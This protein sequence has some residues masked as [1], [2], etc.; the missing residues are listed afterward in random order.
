MES[1]RAPHQYASLD[2]ALTAW[3]MP[4]E[5]WDLIERFTNR[6][7][8]AAYIETLDSIRAVRF[9][10][11]PDLFIHVALTTGFVSEEEARESTGSDAVWFWGEQQVWGVDHPVKKVSTK[12]PPAKPATPAK[13]PRT[14]FG[15]C[16][17]CF[18]TISPAGTCACPDVKHF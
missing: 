9:G 10:T 13:Q 8:I 12:A 2:E 14:D 5:N 11:G 3:K 15:V 18:T 17:E 7:G 4:L 6:I 16:T 1:T